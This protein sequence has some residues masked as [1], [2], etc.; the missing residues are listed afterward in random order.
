MKKFLENFQH[1]EVKRTIYVLDKFEI[2]QGIS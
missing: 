2:K 1:L